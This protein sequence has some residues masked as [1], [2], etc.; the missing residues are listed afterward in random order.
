MSD[1]GDCDDILAITIIMSNDA[2]I[3]M[4]INDVDAIVTTMIM[5]TDDA[6]IQFYGY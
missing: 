5:N 3:I 1:D 4:I 2:A 6:I